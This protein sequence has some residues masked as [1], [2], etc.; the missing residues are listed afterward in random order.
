MKPCDLEATVNTG[1]DDAG[2]GKLNT[3][4]N[5]PTVQEVIEF[6]KRFQPDQII[7]IYRGEGGDWILVSGKEE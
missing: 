3:N 4:I 2:Y 6:L 7:G 5:P 1:P